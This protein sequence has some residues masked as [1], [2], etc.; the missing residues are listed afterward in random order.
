MFKNLSSGNHSSINTLL[1]DP[2]TQQS[3]YLIFNVR[4]TSLMDLY[5]CAVYDTCSWGKIEKRK[6]E[7]LI[8]VLL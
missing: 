6:K 2:D 3:R 5:L 4:V 7:M 1:D 8:L